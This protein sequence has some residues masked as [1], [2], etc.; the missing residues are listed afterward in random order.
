MSTDAP[1]WDD[2]EDIED[3]GHQFVPYD[4]T[5]CT[6][7]DGVPTEDAEVRW[8][9]YA[10]SSTESTFDYALFRAD[11]VQVYIAVHDEDLIDVEP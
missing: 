6:P 7:H 9:S 11:D 3:P 8:A 2:L 5:P 10:D 1:S 4:E